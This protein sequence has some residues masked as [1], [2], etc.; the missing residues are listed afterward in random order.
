[1]RGEVG[2]WRQPFALATAS[3]QM[4]EER[5]TGGRGQADVDDYVCRRLGKQ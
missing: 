3:D 1:M 2:R 4:M 5:R